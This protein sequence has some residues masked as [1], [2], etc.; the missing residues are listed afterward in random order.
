MCKYCNLGSI[1]YEIVQL[2]ITIMITLVFSHIIQN[3]QP[4]I[5]FQIQERIAAPI[6][7]LCHFLLALF[8]K[9][10]LLLFVQKKVLFLEVKISCKITTV[11]EK[12]F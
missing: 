8:S 6:Y 4:L 1:W 10:F 3:S 7:I 9:S 12:Q 2:I 11:K 5:K